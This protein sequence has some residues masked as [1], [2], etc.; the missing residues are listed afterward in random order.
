MLPPLPSLVPASE[1]K[2][3]EEPHEPEEEWGETLAGA[4]ADLSSLGSSEKRRLLVIGS[5]NGELAYYLAMLCLDQAKTDKGFAFRVRGTDHFST[6]V[7]TA[8]RGVYRDHQIEF[9]E[10]AVRD[11]WM[12]RGEGDD[13]Y[14]WKVGDQPR[15]HVE[16]EVADFQQGKLFFPQPCHLIILNQGIE[17]VIDDKKVHLLKTICDRL[18][19]GAA[20]VVTGPLKRELLPE[21][22]KRT[23]TA[24]FRKA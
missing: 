2:K 4:V 8:L 9:V 6:R 24:V 10:P 18:L 13:R 17:H 19:P 11:T 1:T 20:L 12:I 3:P 21:G 5:G 23:G 22:M 15:L 7:E 16:F 14:L